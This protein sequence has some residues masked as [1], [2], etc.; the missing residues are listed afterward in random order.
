MHSKDVSWIENTYVSYQRSAIVPV[1]YDYF[2]E[3]QHKLSSIVVESNRSI[4]DYSE[5]VTMIDFANQFIGGGVL[6]YGNVQEEIMFTIYPECLISIL[7][8]PCMKKNEAISIKGALR[9]TNHRGYGSSFTYVG[10]R[11]DMAELDEERRVKNYIVAIDALELMTEPS[12]QYTKNKVLREL[13]KALAG[14]GLGNEKIVTGKWG[15]GMFGGDPE[16]KFI[17]QWVVASV[18]DKEMAFMTF[19]DTDLTVKIE[20]LVQKYRN[21]NVAKLMGDLGA[22]LDHQGD[23]I[24]GLLEN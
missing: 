9:T 15:C 13:N 8:C 4:E 17:I 21:E 3:N 7:I 24:N 23:L 22:V 5:N 18:L 14:F 16:L 6:G 20:N 19:N 12:V 11:D 1:E 10:P 2:A